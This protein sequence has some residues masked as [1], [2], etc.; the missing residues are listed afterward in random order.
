MLSVSG[1]VSLAT[2]SPSHSPHLSPSNSPL[3]M[4]R[5]ASPIAPLKQ[6]TTPKKSNNTTIQVRLQV[7]IVY[8][9][10]SYTEKYRNINVKAVL[11]D[12]LI[13]TANWM[14]SISP[15]ICLWSR[16]QEDICFIIFFHRV[17]YELKCH[18][19]NKQ[20]LCVRCHC[21]WNHIDLT[22][23]PWTHKEKDLSHFVWW[24]SD[25][26]WY[27]GICLWYSCVL[28]YPPWH[29]IDFLMLVTG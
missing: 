1:G 4:R 18:S 28:S 7:Y 5:T 3:M 23:E 13:Q 25:R 12:I 8:S 17:M 27:T 21:V 22:F 2:T 9:V 26:L 19:I 14:K 29:L 11:G 16:D 6:T 24:R 10:Q 15:F 20:M